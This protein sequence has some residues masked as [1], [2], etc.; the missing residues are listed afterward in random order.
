[1]VRP[2]AGDDKA[3][4]GPFWA[5]YEL[6]TNL[7]EGRNN[8]RLESGAARRSGMWRSSGPRHVQFDV[9]RPTPLR[10]LSLLAA[11]PGEQAAESDPRGPFADWEDRLPELQSRLLV[12]YA[13]SARPLPWRT[14]DDSYA[15]LVSEIMLQQTQ[16]ERVIPKY[17][18]FLGLFPTLGALASASR[19]DVIRAWA[20]L[21]Y[22]RRAVRLHALAQ[23]VAAE[24]Q[25]R[26]PETAPEL[27][28][29]AGLG[30]YTSAAVACFAFG[31]QVA[32]IDTNVRR[33]LG[34][35]AADLMEEQSGRQSPRLFDRLASGALP[36][37]RASEWNQALMDLGATI[38]SARAPACSVCPVVDLCAA[39]GLPETESFPA[40]SRAAESKGAYR[41]K[42]TFAGSSRYF[43]GRVVDVLRQLGPDESLHL[44]EL[45]RRVRPH[46]AADDLAWLEELVRGLAADGLVELMLEIK[47]EAQ[48]PLVRLP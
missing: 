6:V 14:T 22:N 7:P 45:G 15:I 30:S 4:C 28:R 34:R 24:H 5:D 2:A 43:R 47:G 38:C 25:G 39:A 13:R 41:V 23:Q 27:A 16:V 31:Q 18:Q 35:L 19:S 9:N 1:M 32:T 29:L 12:W 3:P 46:F 36:P 44:S 11:E 8:V 21:G 17:H 33:V 48:E 37:G 20:G 42:E 10:Q 26:L 40:V